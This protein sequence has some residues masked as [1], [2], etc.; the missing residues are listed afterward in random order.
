[1][2]EMRRQQFRKRAVN[3]GGMR[4]A[5]RAKSTLPSGV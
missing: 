1:M 3:D 4:V 5:W 2:I